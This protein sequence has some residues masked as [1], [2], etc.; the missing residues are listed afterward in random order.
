M[1]ILFI[2]STRIGDAVLSTGLLDHIARTYP[3]AR[4]TIVCGPLV[5]SLFEGYTH[6]EKLIKLRK[7]KHNKHWARLWKKVIG[8]RW[9]MV[10]DLRN[11]AVSRLIFAKKRYI[12]TSTIDKNLHK[13]EQNAAVMKLDYVPSPRLWFTEAQKTAAAEL[14]PDGGSVLG[15][16][17]SANWAAKT[18]PPQRFIDVM[19]A[20]TGPNG[21]LPGARIAVF[22]APSEEI[23]AHQVLYAAPEERQI[24]VVAKGDPGTAAAALARCDFYIGNDSGLM[25]CAAA[26]GVPTLGLFGPS[27]PHLYRPWGPKAAYVAT[28]ESFDQLIAYEGYSAK[29]AP[30]LMESL[31]AD[32]VTRAAQS[33]WKKI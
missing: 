8:T 10:V 29:T 27:Y 13:A 5:T 19:Y 28:P 33:L 3:E 25:H 15:I 2:T 12:F 23:A 1:K 6:L 31:S 7:Q 32:E 30:C 16:G 22:G 24:D 18:W 26:S 14:V 9:D 17:P 20:L 4:V 21:I 11:S